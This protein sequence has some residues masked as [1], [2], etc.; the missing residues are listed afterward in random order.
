MEEWED[1]END[2]QRGKRGEG[3]FKYKKVFILPKS[4]TKK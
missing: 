3:F 2:K 4:S 1:G